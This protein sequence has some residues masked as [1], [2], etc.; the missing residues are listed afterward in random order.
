MNNS[1][2]DTNNKN[3]KIID[4]NSGRNNDLKKTE[5]VDQENYQDIVLNQIKQW[6]S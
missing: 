3:R 1:K 6:F 5:S 2:D 4:N